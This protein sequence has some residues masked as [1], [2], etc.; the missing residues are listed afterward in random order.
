MLRARKA[1]VKHLSLNLLH[2]IFALRTENLNS[3]L[4]GIYF[5]PVGYKRVGDVRE[6][7]RPWKR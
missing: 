2:L 6:W 3:F 5:I 1:N 4:L 7:V